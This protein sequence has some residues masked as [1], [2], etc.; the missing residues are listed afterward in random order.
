MKVLLLLFFF[1]LRKEC[2]NV[3]SYLPQL[4]HHV[5]AYK[6]RQ[7]ILFS[8]VITICCDRKHQ[9]NAWETREVCHRQT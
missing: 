1:L 5:S 3:S 9:Y 6:I 8:E 2:I 4:T 7:L